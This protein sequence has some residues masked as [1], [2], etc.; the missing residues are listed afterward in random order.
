MY[1]ATDTVPYS[2]GFL[3]KIRYRTCSV[4][5][6]GYGTAPVATAN[7]ITPLLASDLLTL[8]SRLH[9][10]VAIADTYE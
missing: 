4:S 9:I 7:Y 1:K 2:G 6:N 8:M 3:L 5:N 10:M